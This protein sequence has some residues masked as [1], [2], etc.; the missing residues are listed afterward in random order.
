MEV[1]GDGRCVKTSARF[2]KILG[3]LGPAFISSGMSWVVPAVSRT[4]VRHVVSGLSWT[5]KRCFRSRLAVDRKI[6]A[7]PW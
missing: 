4:D 7:C 3:I 6:N 1:V 2:L 5:Q